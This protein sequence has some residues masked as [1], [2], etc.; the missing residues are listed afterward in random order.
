MYA[1][2]G[3]YTTALEYARPAVEIARQTQSLQS[4]SLFL[5]TYGRSFLA[6]GM[7]DEARQAFLEGLAIAESFGD[8]F[9]QVYYHL[10]LGAMALADGHPSDARVSFE[11]AVESHAHWARLMS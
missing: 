6:L 5:D 10:G 2:L 8:L 7:L 11:I 9:S 4:L 3:L 1:D